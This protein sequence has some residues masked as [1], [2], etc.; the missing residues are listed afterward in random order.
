MATLRWL[1]VLKSVVFLLVSLIGDLN[2][3]T[4]HSKIWKFLIMKVGF[5]FAARQFWALLAYN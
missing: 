3:G 5:R 1:R 2:I 4:M